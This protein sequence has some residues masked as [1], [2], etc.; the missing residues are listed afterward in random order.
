MNAFQIIMYKNI[1]HSD[2][3]ATAPKFP[4]PAL[5]K[6]KKSSTEQFAALNK[7]RKPAERVRA[8]VLSYNA[9]SRANNKDAVGECAEEQS[10]IDCDVTVAEQTVRQ[11]EESDGT[12]QHERH[13]AENEPLREARNAYLQAVVSRP[14]KVGGAAKKNGGASANKQFGRLAAHNKTSAYKQSRF[15]S[16]KPVTDPVELAPTTSTKSTEEPNINDSTPCITE[17][18]GATK[19]G[20]AAEVAAVQQGN[21]GRD[22]ELREYDELVSYFS[23]NGYTEPESKRGEKK[24]RAKV[25]VVH[26][27]SGGRKRQQ[28]DLLKY[29]F[30]FSA[31]DYDQFSHFS[32]TEDIDPEYLS[33]HNGSFK[34]STK[35]AELFITGKKV[36]VLSVVDKKKV[37]RVQSL[38]L[39]ERSRSEEEKKNRGARDMAMSELNDSVS[40]DKSDVC[41]LDNLCAGAENET[42]VQNMERAEGKDAVMISSFRVE[43]KCVTSL[44]SVAEAVNKCSGEPGPVDPNDSHNAHA[45]IR[46]IARRRNNNGGALKKNNHH[47]VTNRYKKSIFS[48]TAE[49]RTGALTRTSQ[50]QSTSTSNS[51]HDSALSQRPPALVSYPDDATSLASGAT[52]PTRQPHTARCPGQQVSTQRPQLGE[53]DSAL[54]RCQAPLHSSRSLPGPGCGHKGLGASK[55]LRGFTLLPARD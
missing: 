19:R 12:Q 16:Y 40:C 27:H 46:A 54:P 25:L 5:S 7:L 41:S 33:R 42:S 23:D 39:P 45:F 26:E 53:R 31:R 8:S 14:K 24:C 13:F 18:R 52:E 35:C 43:E 51:N 3:E 48:N 6:S 17:P 2:L 9:L 1:V 49:H 29:E 37:A 55:S 15:A 47:T 10:T 50:G 30:M 28:S 44:T 32:Y 4:K 21:G 11:E 20:D 22:A 38:L 36:V 34:K